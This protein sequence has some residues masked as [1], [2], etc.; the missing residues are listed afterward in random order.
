MPLKP[1]NVIAV[2]G[3]RVELVAEIV[4]GARDEPQALLALVRDRL[5]DHRLEILTDPAIL[6]PDG[7]SVASVIVSRDALS[8]VHHQG[9]ESLGLSPSETEAGAT[10]Q[11]SLFG[12]VFG[13][14]SRRS[15]L[16]RWMV[17]Y[18]RAR[19]LSVR[20][21]RFESLLLEEVPPGPVADVA[22]PAIDALIAAAAAVWRLELQPGLEGLTALED[23]IL[24]ERA[25]KPGR[26]VLQ[27][28][29]V[30]ALAAFTGASIHTLA[31]ETA[32]TDDEDAPLHI[33]APRGAVVRSDP[34]SRV[35]DLVAHGRQALLRDYAE[36]VVRQSLTAGAR[37]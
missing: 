17:P 33:C 3:D 1:A 6:D 16:D 2:K 24:R 20:L 35:V 25:S 34:I 7:V 30:I 5:A 32:W 26:W 29:A 12:G 11:S 13:A 28:A 14:K 27:P 18:Y 9:L 10:E 37:T 36:S 4:D 21:G 19:D 23:T 31:R 15:K 8:P 22:D